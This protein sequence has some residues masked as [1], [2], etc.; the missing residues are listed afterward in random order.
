MRRRCFPHINLLFVLLLSLIIVF[1]VLWWRNQNWLCRV[2]QSSRIVNYGERGLEARMEGRRG[3]VKVLCKS[4]TSENWEEPGEGGCV[5]R[6]K[7]GTADQHI[8]QNFL[9]DPHTG[10]VYCYA[11]K[12]ASSTWMSVFAKVEGDPRF[13]SMVEK[14]SGWYRVANRIAASAAKVARAPVAMMVVR[15]PFDRLL[16]AFKD[17]ILREESDQAHQHLPGILLHQP[18]KREEGSPT[19]SQ[20]LGYVIDGGSDPHWNSLS[21][22]CAPCLV[23][24]DWILRLED[25]TL[26]MDSAAFLQTTGM[27][28]RLPG[29]MV[30]VHREGVPSQD[31]R[32]LWIDVPCHL[33]ADIHTI[34]SADFLLFGYSALEYLKVAGSN[35]SFH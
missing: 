14:D 20:F 5:Y 19:F 7:D 3:R 25:P 2:N 9:Q 1:T 11:H 32:H 30:A 12:V 24:Y 6:S 4:W 17:R 28:S 26:E 34:F 22:M 13:L 27:A 23:D 8:G 35:C 31:Y 18:G 10:T 21:S 15:H 16:S 29:G 33:L